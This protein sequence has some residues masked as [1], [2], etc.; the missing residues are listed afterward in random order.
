MTQIEKILALVQEEDLENI[1]KLIAVDKCNTKLTGKIMFKGMMRL[2]L[3]HQKTSLRILENVINNF[4]MHKNN[5]KNT[6]TYSGISKRLNT[7]NPEYF[8]KIYSDILDKASRMIHVKTS[9]NLYR[10]DSTII[11]L[12]GLLL[13]DGLKIHNSNENMQIKVSI[14]LKNQLPTSIRFCAERSEINENVALVRAI[15]DARIE[16]EKDILLFDRGISKTQAFVDF[17]EQEYKFVT[18][19]CLNRRYDIVKHNNIDRK[20]CEDGS[21]IIQDLVVNLYQKSAKAPIKHDLRL[22]KLKNAR[23]DEIW[24]L[25]NL[26]ETPAHEVTELYRRRWDIEVFFKFIKQNL[27]YKHFLS[28]SMNGMKAYIYMIMITALLFLI[29]KNM[30]NLTGF[31]IPLFQFALDLTISSVQSIILLAGGDPSLVDS[32]I[33]RQF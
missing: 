28:Y 2:I 21:E 9:R 24:F 19:V 12:S 15:N 26:F 11:S 33:R 13:K 4:V 30:N 29:Y 22:I 8:E 5:D 23:E 32:L 14:G 7:I 25:T 3:I 6:V 20:Y 16:K 17:D 18:R 1:G 10:F 31:K 27:G